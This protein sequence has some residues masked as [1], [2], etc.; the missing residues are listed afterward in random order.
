MSKSTGAAKRSLSAGPTRRQFMQAVGGL[1][2]GGVC[3]SAQSG[4]RRSTVS[5]PTRIG[6]FGPSHCSVPFVYAKATDQFSREQ[7]RV[8][9][10]NYPAMSEIVADL[11]SGKLDFGQLTVPLA[12][13]LHVGSGPATE[14]VPIVIP[15]ITGTHGAALLIREGAGIKRA[16]DLKGR[17]IANHSKLTVHR[18]LTTMFLA[19]H[20]L[21]T[22]GDVDHQVILLSEAEAAL[23]NAAVDAVIL[24]EP[25]IAALE[26]AGLGKV[27]ILTRYLWQ[28]HPCCALVT[29][30]QM[31]EHEPQRVQAVT[32]AMLRA[33][34]AADEA[35][36][37]GETITRLRGASGYGFD[38]LPREVLER[39]F[40]PGRSDFA[41]F[42]F[43]STMQ[44]LATE[45]RSQGVLKPGVDVTGVAEEVTLAD[46]TRARLKE[47]GGPAPQSNYRAE[48][49]MGEVWTPQVAG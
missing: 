22:A 40:I 31:L 25:R 29:R 20:G 28:N 13:A 15:Q 8:E 30:R 33:G 6:V 38:K 39:A 14:P 7:V 32:R 36:T 45:L 49:I 11:A 26:H 34:L 46:F 44:L 10:V 9:L 37:R 18:T 23:R 27:F 24:P 17:T 35:D 16:T 47:I 12:L 5:R 1:A 4:A 3:W 48:K 19:H 21:D 2:L 42:P 41:P 43:V